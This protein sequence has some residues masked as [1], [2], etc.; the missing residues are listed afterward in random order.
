MRE[1]G[2]AGLNADLGPAVVERA[3]PGLKAKLL[4]RG[5]GSVNLVHEITQAKIRRAK[6]LLVGWAGL[7]ND[8][9]FMGEANKMMGTAFQMVVK[10]FLSNEAYGKN[11]CLRQTSISLGLDGSAFDPGAFL[12]S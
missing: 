3:L 2:Q 6:N 11:E 8:G 5:V 9:T 10:T 1:L 7:V 12:E 4:N